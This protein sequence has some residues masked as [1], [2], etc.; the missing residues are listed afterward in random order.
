MKNHTLQK[1]LNIVILEFILPYTFYWAPHS[2]YKM[3]KY[4]YT[5]IAFESLVWLF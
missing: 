2:D 1:I 5:N 3:Y 4:L